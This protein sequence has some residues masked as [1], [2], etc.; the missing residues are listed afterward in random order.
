MQAMVAAK[1]AEHQAAGWTVRFT[2]GTF[3]SVLPQP[4]GGEGTGFQSMR[5][6]FR[7]QY[8]RMESE[9]LF[10]FTVQQVRSAPYES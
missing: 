5:E 7:R 9:D 6:R 2:N 10:S 4:H 8:I 1:A 3:A